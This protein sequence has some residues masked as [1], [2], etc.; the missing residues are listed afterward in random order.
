MEKQ[1][2]IR[3]IL[4]RWPSRQALADDAGVDLFAVHRWFQRGSV[5]ARH[6]AALMRGA[7][8]RKIKVSLEDLSKARSVHSE[9]RG[10]GRV[11]FQG[12]ES[13]RAAQ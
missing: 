13:E 1:L 6:D 4:L 10:H 3:N 5:N 7:K 11:K 2:T 9:Q 12:L 8:R